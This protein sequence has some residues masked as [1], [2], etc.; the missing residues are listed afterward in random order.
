MALTL[1]ALLGTEMLFLAQSSVFSCVALM[2]GH[3]GGVVTVFEFYTEARK[4][5]Y[6]FIKGLLTALCEIG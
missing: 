3:C 1:E 6:S 2:L 5:Y 4:T